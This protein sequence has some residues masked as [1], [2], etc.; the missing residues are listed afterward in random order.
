LPPRRPVH[1][2]GSLKW[3]ANQPPLLAGQTPGRRTN[4]PPHPRPPRRHCPASRSALAP[5]GWSGSAA[6]PWRSAASSSSATPSMPGCLG[7]ACASCS[8]GCLRL[9]C[10]PRA[11]RRGGARTPPPSRSCR[12]PIFRRSSPRPGLRSPLQPSMPLMRCTT[13]WRQRPPSSCSVWSHSAPLPR[14]CCMGRCWPVSASSALSPPLSSFLR[15][16]PISGRSISTSR[17]SPRRPSAWRGSDCG[18]GSRSVPSRSRCS[19]PCPS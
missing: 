3:R 2:P 6:R 19:G 15:K 14:L 5:V 16:G 7:R 18:A 8:A 13:F 17:S 10:L 11:N 4:R 12:S 9:P 1:Q